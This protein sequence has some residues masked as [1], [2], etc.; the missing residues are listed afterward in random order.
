MAHARYRRPYC[1]VGKTEITEKSD[2]AAYANFF[3]A[4][5][6]IISVKSQHS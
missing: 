2:Y 3:P 6:K 5:E 4:V 1:L